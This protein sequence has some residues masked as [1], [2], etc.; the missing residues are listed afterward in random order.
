MP[1][2]SNADLY[3]SHL[4]GRRDT[5]PRLATPVVLFRAVHTTHI[6]EQPLAQQVGRRS[7]SSTGRH[8]SPGIPQKGMG[9]PL[10]VRALE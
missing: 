9:P 5:G 1:T 7:D 10:D 3:P 4:H 8:A 6:A 2:T